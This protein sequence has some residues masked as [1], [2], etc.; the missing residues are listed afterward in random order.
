M[1]QNFEQI[2]RDSVSN[3]EV[4]YEAGAWEKFQ[5]NIPTSTPFYKSKWFMAAGLF[6]VVVASIVGYSMLEKDTNKIEQ[7]I[8]AQTNKTGISTPISI[9]DNKVIV[10]S[11][12]GKVITSTET[13]DNTVSNNSAT[14]NDGDDRDLNISPIIIPETPTSKPTLPVTP[15]KIKEPNT[16]E[17]IIISE[18]EMVSAEF[19]LAK[20]V[21]EGN[22]VYLIADDNKPSHTYVWNIN[23]RELIKG[24]NVNFKVSKTGI[25]TITLSVRNAEGK[26]VATK[27]STI[28]VI[29]LP[30]IANEIEND[31]FS[32]KNDFKFEITPSINTTVKWNLGDGTK[33]NEAS[34][35]HTYKQGGVYTTTCTVTNEHGCATTATKKVDVK[36]LYNIRPDYG[37]SPNGDNMNDN[38]LPVELKSLDVKFTMNIYSRNGQLIY[39]TNSIEQP[40]NGMMQDG[41]K[42][43]FG[44]YVW[45]VTLTNE[46]GN[47][48]V[49]KGTVTNVTN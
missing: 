9:N 47:Q 40:W 34:F 42:S 49:Y 17:P 7:A 25:N 22:T 16:P 38:F 3:H 31:K 4:P 36:G 19:F 18:P 45:V 48:E 1:K 37:F 14:N 44:S 5:S 26:V 35:N 30:E 27:S 29:E 15:D 43:P 13:Q 39:T 33:S 12:E 2:I 23:N 10:S 24:T 32:V 46:F 41:S 11:T 21:C 20:K 28:E 8:V 6:A